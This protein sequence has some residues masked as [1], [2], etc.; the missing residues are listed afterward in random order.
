[1]GPRI[2]QQDTQ[3]GNQ[4]TKWYADRETTDRKVHRE[5]QQTQGTQGGKRQTTR[6]T[7]RKEQTIRD[8]ERE[9][10]THGAQR[11]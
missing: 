7:K 2:F 3:K 10:T 1:M 5:K 8:I 6:H 4:Q 11:G 9:T